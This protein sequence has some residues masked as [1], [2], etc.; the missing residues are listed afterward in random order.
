MAA[1][2]VAFSGAPFSWR[3]HPFSGVKNMQY[4][5]KTKQWK[6]NII[7]RKNFL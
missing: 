1:T 2:P 5:I 7:L 4:T 3:T 6:Q